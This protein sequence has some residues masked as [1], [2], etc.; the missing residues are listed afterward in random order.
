MKRRFFLILAAGLALLLAACST[1]TD[2]TAATDG[3]EEVSGDADENDAAEADADTDDDAAE[4]PPFHVRGSVEQIHIW[5]APPETA[6]ELVGLS[7]SVEQSATTDYQGSL[8]F[9]N[10][11][12]GEGYAVRLAGDPDV[13]VNDVTVMSVEGSLPD[14][15]FYASQRLEPGYGYLTTRD[16]TTLS[17]FVSLPGPVEEGPYPT[18]INYSGYSPSAPGESLGGAAELFCGEFPVLCDAPHHPEG[19]IGGIMGFATAGVNIRGTGCSGGA[20]D[21]FEPLQ[22]LDGYDVIEVVARQ[23]W[24]KHHKVGMVGLSYPGISQL[25]VASTRPPSLA[26]I[27][28]MS[29]IADT[30]TSTLLPG[31]IYNTGFALQW[32]ENV[33]EK[34][35]PYAHQ[36]ITDRVDGGDTICEENQL[37]H[38]QQLDAIA[39]ALENPF[40]SDEIGGPVNPTTFVDKIE[41]PVFL[42][43]QCQDEQTGPHFAALFDKFVN[44]PLVRF[45][46]TNGVHA[47]GY[48]PQILGEWLT[49]LSLTVNRELPSIPSNA[50]AL[51]GMF[52][53]IIYDEPNLDMPPLRYDVYADYE[54]AMQD[55]E[56]ENPVRVIFESGAAPDLSP[57]APQGIFEARFREWPIPETT[58]LR[59]YFQPDGSLAE[60]A[61]PADGGAGAFEPD[62]EAGDRVTLQSG[63]VDAL[64][65]DYIYR[66][67]APSKALSFIGAPL[68]DNLAMVGSGSV[69][70][71]LKSSAE[72]ADLEVNLTEVR[73]DGMESY[74]QSGWLRASRRTLKEESTELRPVSSHYENDAHP[75]DP[76]AWNLVR[77]E[78]MPFA[79]VFRAGSRIR[80]SVDTPGDSR[81]WWRFK[82]LEF[83]TPPTHSV[84]HNADFP[85]RIVLPG[86]PGI[87]VMGERADCHALRG[88]PCRDYEPFENQPAR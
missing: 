86:V 60:Q 37:L 48:A 74:V 2:N 26:A 4:A 6:M 81:A 15:E 70:L 42:A 78:L 50:A 22:L 33:L 44:A 54:T 51:T 41:V 14:E 64:Q 18:L 21:Y 43:G 5:G 29:V 83:E 63:S 75:L 84:A 25:F 76:E 40:Y 58:P 85:S 52:M 53:E 67:L 56:A 32:I 46:M 68:E 30:Y 16:G 79:H 62:P 47:D 73:P 49:F 13:A 38:S 66:Q 23:E 34:A 88:Q 1:E 87:E 19:I 28:P 35:Q 65:P 20:Y 80:I 36:W 72:D 82:L 11:A 77:V 55:Y 59:L 61:P 39:K 27:A 12:P 10:R 17:I 45:T 69:D 57:G 8:I 7:G 71:W 3:D 31:G 24:V 9:R